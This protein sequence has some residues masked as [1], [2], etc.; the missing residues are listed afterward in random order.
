MEWEEVGRGEERVQ[1]SQICFGSVFR[2]VCRLMVLCL[3][4]DERGVDYVLWSAVEGETGVELA[5][6]GVKLVAQV[7]LAEF[8]IPLA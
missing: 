5:E 7:E 4:L 1:Q 8:C 3:A 6:H 2:F